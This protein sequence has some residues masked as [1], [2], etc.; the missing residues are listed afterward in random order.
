MKVQNA[1]P[2]LVPSSHYSFHPACRSLLTE[3]QPLNVTRLCG[4]LVLESVAA[5]QRLVSMIRGER[6]PCP[7][8]HFFG[9]PHSLTRHSRNQTDSSQYP[10]TDSLTVAAH[11]ENTDSLTV[12]VQSENTDSP[13]VAVRSDRVKVGPLMSP[14]SA[15]LRMVR[16]GPLF[17]TF[18]TRICLPSPE[19]IGGAART[20]GASRWRRSSTTPSRAS[21]CWS[22]RKGPPSNPSPN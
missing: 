11:S 6:L 19:T 21:K 5:R 9:T 15:R 2:Y 8:P 20:S 14:I 12:A 1:G 18:E 7:S 16:C 10:T 3:E 22:I 17:H 13:T 4:G